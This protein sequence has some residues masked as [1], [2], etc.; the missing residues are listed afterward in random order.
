MTDLIFAY[1]PDLS[2][3][4]RERILEGEK[5]EGFARRC[6]NIW[7]HAEVTSKFSKERR[8][9]LLNTQRTRAAESDASWPTS[10]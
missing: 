6:Q 4:A 8:R 3:V 5:A 2:M 7:R 1:G 10:S 9:T